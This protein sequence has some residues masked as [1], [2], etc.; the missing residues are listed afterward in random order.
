MSLSL[1]AVEKS[2]ALNPMQVRVLGG[3]PYNE[4]PV[5]TTT[6]R[7]VT[8]SGP[9]I[10]AVGDAVA[11][12]VERY[13]ALR[14][15]VVQDRDGVLRQQ[16]MSPGSALSSIEWQV[17]EA[18]SGHA[19]PLVDPGTGPMRYV[20]EADGGAVRAVTVAVSA[21]FA[22]R[23][24]N[25]LL[26]DDL[27]A[28]IAGT[29][30]VP[31]DPDG[32]AGRYS[33]ER[34]AVVADRNT[35][36]WAGLL[37]G[38][39]RSLT[40]AGVE[41]DRVERV[42]VCRSTLPARLGAQVAMSCLLYGTTP[43]VLWSAAAHIVISRLTDTHHLV[44]RTTVPNRGS[45]PAQSA[46]ACL[47]Q[48]VL[49]PVAGKP[50]D[51]LTE[52]V[53]RVHE[54]FLLGEEHGVHSFDD[55]PHRLCDG[56]VTGFQP[57]FEIGYNPC[58]AESGDG[59][60]TGTFETSETFETEDLLDRGAGR[61]D[62]RIGVQ[63]S[64]S[65]VTATVALLRPLWR[66]CSPERFRDHLVDVLWDLCTRPDAPVASVAVDRPAVRA[67]LRPGHHS[68]VAID[69]PMMRRLLM[70]PE[71][72]VGAEY[73]LVPRVNGGHSL[74]AVL[75]TTGPADERSLRESYARYQMWL[76]G[77]VVPDQLQIRIDGRG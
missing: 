41:R 63:S 28:L 12:L 65:A 15:R 36:F 62:V 4:R 31:V 47:E 61:V 50:G 30:I 72:V 55:L 76:A 71:G 17:V 26:Q 59:R 9:P 6:V 27:S 7:V 23:A 14:S 57:A 48:A 77:T 2:F 29:P 32:Q 73:H 67:G 75:T 20:V 58:P 3:W 34:L 21:A 39:P 33:G 11:R 69:E 43:Q 64:P 66:L 40:Y 13:E 10:D 56:P 44:F 5:P 60:S 24:S 68:G 49:L 22:D 1:V 42:R 18:A 8:A 19:V 45:S 70:S 38:A 74:V 25:P 53:S 35:R 16:V 52:R 51:T 46:V 54:M 37:S